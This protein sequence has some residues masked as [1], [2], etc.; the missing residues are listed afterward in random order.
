MEPQYNKEDCTIGL[1]PD[2]EVCIMTMPLK[3]YA[4]DDRNGGALL[5]GKFKELEVYARNLFIGMIQKRK[6]AGIVRVNGTTP[7]N[8]KVT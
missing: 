6:A 3:A 8:L 2:G 4:D 1:S 7:P 5:A